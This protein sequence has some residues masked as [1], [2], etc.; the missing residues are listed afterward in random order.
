MASEDKI[1]E[2]NDADIE[3]AHGGALLEP[4]VTRTPKRPDISVLTKSD[5]AGYRE[6]F[7]VELEVDPTIKTGKKPTTKLG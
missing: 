4:F 1:Q 2:L 7:G 3:T 5:L 6:E